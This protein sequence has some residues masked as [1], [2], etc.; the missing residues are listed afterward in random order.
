MKSYSNR[1]PL[2][3]HQKKAVSLAACAFFLCLAAVAQNNEASNNEVYGSNIDRTA[4]TT[5]N[6]GSTDLDI[7]NPLTTSLALNHEV[8][9]YVTVSNSFNT[10]S[11][12]ATGASLASPNTASLSIFGGTNLLITGGTFGAG[13]LNVASNA[14]TEA[15]GGRLSDVK[16]ADIQDAVFTGQSAESDSISTGGAPPLPGASTAANASGSTG[17]ILENATFADISGSTLTGGTAGNASDTGTN[18]FAIGGTGLSLYSSSAVLSNVTVSGGAGGAAGAYGNYSAFASGGHGIQASN[19]TVV[20]HSGTFNAG[21]AGSVN[22]TDDAGGYALY[23]RDG[24]SVTNH[25]GTFNAAGELHSVVIKNSDLTTYGGTYSGEGLLGV[26]TGSGTNNLYLSGGNFNGLSFINS[27]NGTQFV[28]VSNISVYSEVYME[29]GTVE[30]D[31]IDN[32]AFQTLEIENGNMI[33]NQD[34]TLSGTLSLNSA[35]STVNF[36]E[37]S[38]ADGGTIDAGTGSI[39]ASGNALFATGSIL[40]LSVITNQAGSLQAAGITFETNSSLTVDASLAGLSSGITNISIISGALSGF[41]TNLMN[42]EIVV[43]ANTNTE[44]RTTAAFDPSGSGLSIIFDTLKLSDYWNA[45]GD[46]ALLANEL[47]DLAPTEMNV[48][49]NNLGA[50]QSAELVQETYFSTMN[51][52]QVAKQGLDSALGLSL[53]RGTEFRDQLAL[54]KSAEGPRGPT[55]EPRNDWRFWMKYYGN[56]YSRSEEGLN[57]EYDATMHGGVIGMDKS[58]GRLLIGLS[59]GMGNYKIDAENG[60]EQTMNAFQGT[61]YST[62]GFGHSF[63]DAGLAYGYNDVDSATA[64][65]LTLEGEF[66]THLISAHLGGGIGFEFAAIGTV[67]TPEASIRYTTYKQNG[68]TETG[69]TAAPRTFDSFDSDSM[70]GSLGLNA[71]MLNSTALETFA[72]K[73]EG[74]AHWLREFNPEPGDLNYQLVGGAN[75]YTIVYPYLDEDT[76]RL[77]V[78]LTFFNTKKRSRKNVLLRLD[79]DELIGEDFNSHNLSAKAIFAF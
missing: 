74:R 22:G 7:F 75:D 1:N 64:D 67:I 52:F 19:S 35:A 43:S 10:F 27:S 72:F 40:N 18:T 6:D 17:L 79:F 69:T 53:S 57:P 49:I 39:V 63:I 9:G 54:P 37:L 44:S 5:F 51:T 62:I 24:S 66:D 29:G 78:G 21:A 3:G 77:G 38:V 26:T 2:A 20:I 36:S 46:F 68:Y 59:G 76:I 65:P 23:A 60:A 73:I 55:A 56:F 12:T 31:N 16:N 32:T 61:L 58:L 30:V 41:D 71:A 15:V 11:I 13:V 42:A 45:T 34:F 25:G 8:S 4:L 50:E 14:W 47:E 28:S 70:V 48:I 33:F